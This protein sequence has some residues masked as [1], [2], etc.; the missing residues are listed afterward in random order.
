[1]GMTLDQIATEALTLP[2]ELRAKLVGT[3]L[4]SFAN[5]G[6]E[7]REVTQVWAEEAERRDDE[8]ERSGEQGVPAEEVFR[9]LGSQAK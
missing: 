8:M 7:D 9:R 4:L 5:T 6:Q 3:L 1:M 2:E